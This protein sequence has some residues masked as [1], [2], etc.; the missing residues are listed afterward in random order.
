MACKACE[1]R[2]KIMLKML[3]TAKDRFNAKFKKVVKNEI[4]NDANDKAD[5]NKIV[6]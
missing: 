6:S 5:Y 2:R 4:K 1:E 3:K